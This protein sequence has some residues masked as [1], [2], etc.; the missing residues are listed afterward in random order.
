M[1]GPLLPIRDDT[2]A[3][4]GFMQVCDDTC[5]EQ[6]RLDWKLITEPMGR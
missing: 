2:P 4:P 3:G 5:L 1:L 6:L